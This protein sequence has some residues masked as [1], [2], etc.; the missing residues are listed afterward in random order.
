MFVNRNIKELEVKKSDG[1]NPMIDSGIRLNVRVV[2]HTSNEL[3]IHFN[4]QMLNSDNV[5]T[6]STES[7]E[8]TIKLKLSLGI[9]AF[10]FIPQN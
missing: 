5:D 3:G 8:Q 4:N 2:D 9:A 1:S 6:E 10:T 7:T